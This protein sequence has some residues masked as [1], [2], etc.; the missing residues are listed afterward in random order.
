MVDW[1]GVPSFD[2]YRPVV[3]PTSSR[4]LGR[5]SIYAIKVL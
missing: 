2:D 4:L 1:S 3:S 5:N